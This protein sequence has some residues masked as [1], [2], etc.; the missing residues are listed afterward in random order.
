IPERAHYH[1]AEEQQ[2]QKVHRAFSYNQSKCA[3]RMYRQIRVK[4]GPPQIMAADFQPNDFKTSFW[5]RQEMKNSALLF[6][7]ISMVGGWGSKSCGAMPGAAAAP[8]APV[9]IL[10]STP[11]AD[12]AAGFVIPAFTSAAAI[13]PCCVMSAALAGCSDPERRTTS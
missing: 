10:P 6:P 8:E 4:A 13:F 7:R 2:D 11:A 3:I 1:E 9:P 5:L 12:Q